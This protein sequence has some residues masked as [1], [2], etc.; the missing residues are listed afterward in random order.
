MVTAT[1]VVEAVR[2]TDVATIEDTEA[3]QRAL[4][5]YSTVNP[6]SNEAS[7]DPSRVKYMYNEK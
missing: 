5:D 1:G 6:E 2:F 4:R 3:G 7:L